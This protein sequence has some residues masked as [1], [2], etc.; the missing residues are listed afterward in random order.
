LISFFR[1]WNFLSYRSFT[2]L[3]R[4]TVR[5]FILFVTCFPNFFLSLFILCLEEGH[6]FAWINFIPSHFA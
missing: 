1:D 6:W 5:Y 4:F 2:S 3:V